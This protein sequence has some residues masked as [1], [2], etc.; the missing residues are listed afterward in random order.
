METARNRFRGSNNIFMM[1]RFVHGID[2]LAHNIKAHREAT[3]YFIVCCDIF[4]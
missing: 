4:T 3:N 2:D 1:E